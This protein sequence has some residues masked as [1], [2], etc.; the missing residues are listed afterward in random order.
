[1]GEGKVVGPEEEDRIR[2]MAW[3]HE[4][5]FGMFIHWGLYSL[6]GRS[7]SV[8]DTK[9]IPVTEYEQLAARFKPKRHTA[10]DWAKLAKRAGM[11]YMVLTTKHHDGFCLFETAS[12]RYCAPKQACERDLVA[13][14]VDAARAEGLRVGFY[15]SL[16]DWHHPDGARCGEDTS[17]RKRFLEYIHRQVH[18]L[19][20]NYGKVD[21]LWY[22]GL[23]Y[24]GLWP[25][26]SEGW[27]SARM[28]RMVR[29]LQPEVIINNRSG[30]PEDF[31]TPEQHVSAEASDR[32]WES[33]MTMNQH[34]GYQEADDQWKKPRDILGHLI[35]C[36][37]DGGNYLIN[38]GPKADGSVPEESVR[39]LSEIGEWM[40]QYGETIY[41]ADSCNVGRHSPFA[42]KFTIKGNVLYIHVPSSAGVGWF[43]SWPGE[44]WLIG[45]LQTKVES[46]RILRTNEPVE[47]SQTQFRVHLKGLPAR[48]PDEPVSVLKLECASA[49]TGQDV[50]FVPNRMTM[51]RGK[52]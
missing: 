52:V 16:E 32:G 8:M 15:Y 2:R 51:P 33:C 3:W 18:E 7:E 5:K 14:Y 36:A 39:I 12:T 49:P 24:G 47:F 48:A 46:A 17:S 20:T 4:A 42:A 29:E 38:I 44:E 40:D 26:S 31:S 6:M 27:E 25:L 28:N 43:P 37:R 41:G 13:E 30:L 23:W 34:W 35:S 9:G 50:I 21:I 11:K 22:D 45:G 19:M 10:R 1:M